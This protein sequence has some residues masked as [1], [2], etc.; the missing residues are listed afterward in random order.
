MSREHQV[1][2]QTLYEWKARAEQA[3]A[4]AFAA[5][6]ASAGQDGQVERAILTLFVEGHTSYRGIVTCV[7]ELCGRTVSLAQIGTLIQTAGRRAKALLETLKPPKTC[8]IALDEQYG[9][10]RGEAYLNIVDARS[11][12]V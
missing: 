5:P 10:E 11:S 6:A 1:S 8:A 4:Q 7:Q 12:V 3:I 2:R 9:E